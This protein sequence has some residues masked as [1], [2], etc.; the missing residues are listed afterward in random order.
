MP[1]L[2]KKLRGGS[3]KAGRAAERPGVTIAVLLSKIT[4]VV[5]LGFLILYSI[6]A[7]VLLLAI[8]ASLAVG[9]MLRSVLP[10]GRFKGWVRSLWS[11]EAGETAYNSTRRRFK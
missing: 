11:G 7:D 8:L 2:R 6:T 4:F 5:L 10:T 9:I 1:D 3:R